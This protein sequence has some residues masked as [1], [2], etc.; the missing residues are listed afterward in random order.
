M[1]NFLNDT[2]V[3]TFKCLYLKWKRLNDHWIISNTTANLIL[4]FFIDIINAYFMSFIWL[5]WLGIDVLVSVYYSLLSHPTTLVS[6]IYTWSLL[7]TKL[8][9]LLYSDWFTSCLIRALIPYHIH[10]LLLLNHV[11]IVVKLCCV[12]GLMEDRC[13]SNKHSR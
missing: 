8:Y 11:V 9:W 12:E 7:P 5:A 13:T 3:N 1:P 4:Y 2:L 6:F 10:L